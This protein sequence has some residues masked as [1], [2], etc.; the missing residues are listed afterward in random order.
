[1]R[2]IMAET[3][4]DVAGRLLDVVLNGSFQSNVAE[5]SI[6]DD[7][8]D[9]IHAALCC[10]SSAQAPIQIPQPELSVTIAPPRQEARPDAAGFQSLANRQRAGDNTRVERLSTAKLGMAADA[11]MDPTT[12]QGHGQGADAAN[13]P[14][15]Y[16]G[17]AATHHHT[18][19]SHTESKCRR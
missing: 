4:Q 15:P 13:Q 7:G 2:E 16:A 17:R 8:G 18:R 12:Q 9:S 14:R 10:R 19:P 1:M 5:L 6:G 11:P 3:G